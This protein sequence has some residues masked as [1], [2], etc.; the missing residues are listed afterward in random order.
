M[1]RTSTAREREVRR[2]D[3]LQLVIGGAT[4]H[5]VA[6]KLNISQAQV[7]ADVRKRLGELAKF[8]LEAANEHRAM[9]E[10]RYNRLLLTVWNTAT[11]GDLEAIDRAVKIL[12]RIDA[13][14]GL[15]QEKP[16]YEDNRN[17]IFINGDDPQAV[18]DK[19]FATM[20]ARG[21]VDGS[22]NGHA[23]ID[24]IPEDEGRPEAGTGGS[25]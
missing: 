9:Q 2:H 11:G 17:Q 23:L 5:Q 10:L 4:E 19:I 1:S 18:I 21:G 3:V 15:V 24:G 16:V 7:N 14:W 12:T 8:D 6:A 20:S 25:G 13:I 22:S